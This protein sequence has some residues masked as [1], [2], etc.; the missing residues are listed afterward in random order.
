MAVAP[1]PTQPDPTSPRPRNRAA[2]LADRAIEASVVLSFTNVGIEARRRL[3]DGWDAELDGTGRVVLVTGATSGLGRAAAVEFA[4]RGATVRFLARDRDK[5][6]RVRDE[7]VEASGNDDVD[8][9]IADL[10][11]LGAV[12]EF[13]DW[14]TR[15]HDRL[16]VLV[17]NAGA[18]LADRVVTEDG[19]E[20]TFQT[21]VAAPALLTSLLL[22]PLR[23]ADGGR[24]VFVSSGGMYSEKLRP[25]RVEMGRDE[26]DGTTAYARA[27]RAQVALVHQWSRWLADDGVT[28][29][30]MH[31]GWADT[32]G[33]EEALPT[34][35]RIVGRF[36]RDPDQGA[37]TIVWLGLAE[38][39][40]DETGG[41]WHD[42]A[43]RPEHKLPSTRLDPAEER[44]REDE[45]WS[46]VVDRSG[47]DPSAFGPEASP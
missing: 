13:A 36:L 11:D 21:Q 34:F 8:F 10:A 1:R 25:A 18:L 37:D 20:F 17:H 19:M 39:A 26:Y 4:S 16:D 15:E 28:V 31:P 12:R 27:K 41:F 40:A 23:A 22:G 24:V 46:L 42:R 9:G 44:R 30:A 5:A 43:R 38:A 14:F 32:P 29:N 35:R 6:K 3:Y 2:A 47:L 45:L 7:I 33:V